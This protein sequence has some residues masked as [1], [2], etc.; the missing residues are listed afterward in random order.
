MT[1]E[2]QVEQA[3]KYFNKLRTEN[4]GWYQVFSRNLNK[5]LD[6]GDYSLDVAIIKIHKVIKKNR[7]FANRMIKEAQ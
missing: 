1:K 2:K 3:I 6:T 5:M 7:R 4:S